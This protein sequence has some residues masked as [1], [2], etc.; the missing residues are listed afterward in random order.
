MLERSVGASQAPL[1]GDR[2]AFQVRELEEQLQPRNDSARPADMQAQRPFPSRNSP[3]LGHIPHQRGHGAGEPLLR[4][5]MPAGLPRHMGQGR[6][7][8]MPPVGRGMQPAAPLLPGMP[9]V[10]HGPQNL[11]RFFMRGMPMNMERFRGPPPLFPL[12]GQDP[13][14]LP[15]GMPFPHG[16]LPPGLLGPAMPWRGP[17]PPNQ[18]HQ[19]QHRQRPFVLMTDREKEWIQKIQ[20][21]QLST[22]DAFHDDYYYLR[23]RELHSSTL[24]AR[25]PLALPIQPGQESERS[26]PFHGRITMFKGSLG[27]CVSTG[28]VHCPRLTVDVTGPINSKTAL[29]P[30]EERRCTMQRRGVPLR[31][32]ED[33]FDLLLTIDDIDHRLED[34]NADHRSL[35]TQRMETLSQLYKLLSVCDYRHRQDASVAA[36]A[37]E[38]ALPLLSLRKGA[39]LFSRVVPLLRADD[40]RR[41]IAALVMSNSS[42]LLRRD[43]SG[44]TMGVLLPSLHPLVEVCG[45]P[46]L[47][48]LLH[49]LLRQP[50]VNNKPAIV[51]L[52]ELQSQAGA[53]F[54]AQLIS[55]GR[56]QCAVPPPLRNFPPPALTSWLESCKQLASIVQPY[57]TTLQQQG[58]KVAEVLSLLDLPVLREKAVV[59]T[60]VVHASAWATCRRWLLAIT[61]QYAACAT[62]LKFVTPSFPVS[63]S[64]SLS[65][66]L[67]HSFP[68]SLFWSVSVIFS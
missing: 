22:T 49:V 24:G 56:K 38:I 14:S 52:L 66:S 2:S 39:R 37:D 50:P 31:T 53:A 3:D 68:C 57:V 64:L 17:L 65:L 26:D 18:Q 48:L 67:S 16:Q 61:R 12:P 19:R 33:G 29:T 11:P 43:D 35:I 44:F 13:R 7:P 20:L 41:D 32:V 6:M 5:P 4:H 54:L 40:H 42:A 63:L 27:S 59:R 1:P 28:S 51:A 21:I 25:P 10:G 45:L 23:Y 9:P 34:S 15:S 8:V 62:F 47:H 36:K 58:S 60:V 55:C 30:A 46:F